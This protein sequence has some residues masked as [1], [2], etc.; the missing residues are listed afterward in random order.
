[1]V[2]WDDQDMDKGVG[3]KARNLSQVESLP[4]PRFFVVTPREV[5][6]LFDGGNPS[7]AELDASMKE[8]VEEAYSSVG[9]SS[10]IRDA[11]DKAK[12]LVGGQRS[13]QRVSIRV[14]SD[15]TGCEYRLNVGPSDF[16]RSLREVASSYTE[17]QDGY[18]ALIVQ[19][20][21]SPEF[22]GAVINKYSQESTL[23]EVVKGL[24]NTLEK[25]TA[26]PHIY[27]LGDREP[28][29]TDI[30][31]K[32]TY[33]VR[34]PSTGERRTRTESF[35]EPPIDS[36]EIKRL[37]GRSTSIGLNLKFVRSRNTFH[38]V[39]AWDESPRFE[40]STDRTLEYVR[41]TEHE[42]CGVA[43]SDFT[44]SKETVEPQ[45]PFVARHGG[46]TSTHAQQARDKGIAAIVR[47]QGEMEEGD[48][49]NADKDRAVGENTATATEV[50]RLGDHRHDAY[51]K[52]SEENLP[53]IGGPDVERIQEF[54]DFFRFDGD[55]VV[56]DTRSLESDGIGTA[57]EYLDAD[58]KTIVLPTDFE[59]ATVEAA[60]RAG[61]DR[62]LVEEGSVDKLRSEVE[63]QERRFILDRIQELD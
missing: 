31:E 16:F 13:A 54:G 34:D 6:R 1:M 58:S 41:A 4:V 21:V 51:G 38:I 62:L 10:G 37:A 55:K 59:A 18:P 29:R 12:S 43:G 52:G 49:L 42:P 20:M 23:V 56:V 44:F 2:V 17:T 27:L 39:D 15:S 63:R 53:I 30:A 25:G 32:Q 50:S 9:I 24:G 45:E 47:Y 40:A 28:L 46:W 14:S 35:E 7:S 26:R 61:F 8:E 22:T 19:K 60:V 48:T 3:T 33:Q 36:S 57:L 11:P 5:Q